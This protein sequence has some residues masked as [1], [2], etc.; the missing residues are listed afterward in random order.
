MPDASVYTDT[1][2]RAASSVGSS[3]ELAALL[4]VTHDQLRK[5]MRGEE[6]PPTEIFL[7]AVDLIDKHYKSDDSA[8]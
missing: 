6:V 2:L 7:R 5:W 8:G 3:H 1:L 4:G